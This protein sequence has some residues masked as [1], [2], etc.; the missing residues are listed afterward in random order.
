MSTKTKLPKLSMI[1]IKL[2]YISYIKK[3][4]ITIFYNIEPA[5]Q[6]SPIIKNFVMKIF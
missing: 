2:I 5:P 3:S 4:E 1:K 6:I